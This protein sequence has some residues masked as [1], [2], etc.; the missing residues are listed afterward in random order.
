MLVPILDRWQPE[1]PALP[2][3]NGLLWALRCPSGAEVAWSQAYAADIWVLSIFELED[4]FK[5][6]Q[7]DILLRYG[8]SMS[9][10]LGGCYFAFVGFCGGSI[11][12]SRSWL[13]STLLNNY[14]IPR[15]SYQYVFCTNFA[16]H[17]WK[18]D[19]LLHRKK[20]QTQ[21]KNLR[22]RLLIA[23]LN[24]CLT[25]ADRI[26]RSVRTNTQTDTN[27]RNQAELT[28]VGIDWALIQANYPLKVSQHP[29]IYHRVSRFRTVR[30]F[31]RFP[32]PSLRLPALGKF[33]PRSPIVLETSA[34]M[35]YIIT[36]IYSITYMDLLGM[37]TSH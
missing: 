29:N 15:V 13:P 16:C 37:I 21:L 26:V 2:Q 4:S 33:G 22:T 11:H 23:H 3:T 9:I 14:D 20:G 19:L 31:N 18:C 17:S 27:Q 5:W 1:H 32:L 10:S 12:F 8:D 35:G 28:D 6:K 36:V 24:A 7:R 30:S 25:H 34:V